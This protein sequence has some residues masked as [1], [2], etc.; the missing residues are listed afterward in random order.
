M[1]Q[2]A[3]Y[4]AYQTNSEAAPSSAEAGF[5]NDTKRPR[6]C[7]AC[8]GLKVRCEPDPGTGPCK[9]CRKANRNC[10]ITAPSRKR[11]KKTDS[12]VAELER[13]I[14][15]LTASLHA[16]KEGN[17]SGSEDDGYGDGDTPQIES[18]DGRS[19]Q[20]TPPYT[21]TSAGTSRKRRL[22]EYQQSGSSG[23]R[24]FSGSEAMSQISPANVANMGPRL[25]APPKSEAGGPDLEPRREVDAVIYGEADVVGRGIVHAETANGLFRHYTDHMAPHM[26]IVVFSPDVRPDATRKRSPVLFL[27]I[28]SVASGQDYP[29]LQATLTK[30][31]MRIL[32][33]RVFIHGEK[34]L[35][36]VQALQVVTIW[37]WPE[38]NGD[39]KY[40]QF[41][42]MTAIMAI[43]L[44]MH[45][46]QP[47]LIVRKEQILGLP[48]PKSYLSDPCT[49][50][51]RRAWLGCYLLC[52]S[53]AMGMRRPNLVQ[54]SSHTEDCLKALEISEDAFPSDKI[55]CRWVQLQR[56]ADEFAAQAS[57]EEDSEITV[58]ARDARTRSAHAHFAKQVS[59][60]EVRSFSELRSRPLSFALNVVNLYMHELAMQYYVGVEP[61]IVPGARGKQR[62][63][64]SPSTMADPSNTPLSSTLGMLDNFLGLSVQGLRSLPVFQFAQ[65]AHGTLTL[66]KI[67]N[68]GKADPE[69]R[70]QMSLSAETV[71]QYVGRLID[72]LR[73]GAEGGKSLPAHSFLMVLHASLDL[74]QEIKHMTLGEIKEHCGGKFPA[75][76]FIQILDLH[77]PT[78]TPR[79]WNYL[80]D[81]Y[82]LEKDVFP[83]G[84]LHLLSEVAAM[85]KSNVNGYGVKEGQLGPQQVAAAAEA[86]AASED[87]FASAVRKMSTNGV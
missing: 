47:L 51:C 12:R 1:Q 85:G 43:D 36:L 70:K 2:A 78:P 53:I 62:I 32:A 49:T 59:E 86:M 68:F 9:R 16:T 74:F 11:Q 55:L 57:A 44:G 83:E 6:A 38:P 63:E 17:V 66:T 30:E 76:N 80:G 45:R 29:D 84:A 54:P 28:L 72:L 26:P 39:S 81:K 60:W 64:S 27:A 77:E 37:Y 65:I 21:T 25:F 35:E 24:R 82:P 48:K 14:D 56:L 13:K 10:V 3:N 18:S 71:E 52:S 61:A 73:T 8:R 19:N 22:S 46:R 67:F 33:D 79:Q 7:E 58:E 4:Q 50:E 20:P 15:A 75:T 5:N 69:Y 40:Y 87:G 34:S 31:I 41:I 23:S 42:Y